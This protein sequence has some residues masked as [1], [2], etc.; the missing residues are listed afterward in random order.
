MLFNLF[1]NFIKRFHILCCLLEIVFLSK[2]LVRMSCSNNYTCMSM[3]AQYSILRLCHDFFFFIKIFSLYRGGIPQWQFW[4][5]LRCTLFTLPHHPSPHPPPTPLK[6]IARSFFFVLFHIGIWSLSP[7][8]PHFHLF[9]LL[10]LS[11]CT[12]CAYFLVLVF[13]IYI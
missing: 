7:I 2:M 5:D 10:S 6:A 9:P 13:V 11:P 3:V 12:H 4:L 1:L 8:Y